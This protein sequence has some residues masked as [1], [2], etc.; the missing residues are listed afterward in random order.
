MSLEL[1]VHGHDYAAGDPKAV[2]RR[3]IDEL[4][5]AGRLEVIDERYAPHMVRAAR[6]WITPFRESFPDVHMEIVESWRSA[7]A[8]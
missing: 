1:E 3:L 6:R 7:R 8:G 5:N 2:V 4:M